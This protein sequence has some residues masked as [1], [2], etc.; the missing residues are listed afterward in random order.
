MRP[1]VT[2]TILGVALSLV[3][4][5]SALAT[6]CVNASK[7][8]QGAGAQIII[9][10]TDGSIDATPGVLRRIDQGLIDLNTGEGFHG[11]IGLDTNGDGDADVSTWFGVGPE[12]DELP[13]NAQLNG[14][15]CQG[16]TNIGIYLTQCVGP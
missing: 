14:P 3:V 11:I 4:A 16:I 8:D 12:G 2:G 6:E 15:P 13:E 9:D 1:R 5:S 7:K 10:L